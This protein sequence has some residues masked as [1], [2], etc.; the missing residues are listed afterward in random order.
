MLKMKAAIVTK[1]GSASHVEV[2]EVLKPVPG[3]K[4]VLIKIIA[5]SVQSGDWRVRALEMPLGMKFLARLIYGWKGPRQKILGT[6]FAGIIEEVGPQVSRWKKGDEVLGAAGMYFGAHAE[7]IVAPEK[8]VL[9]KKPSQISFEEAAVLSFGGLTALDYLKYKAKV[10]KQDKILIIG[11]SGAVGVSA[12][13]IARILG[14]HIT[15]VCSEE[16]S[17]IV[18]SLGAEAII[19]YQKENFWEKS[20]KFDIVLDCVGGFPISNLKKVT[21]A[22]GKIVLVSANLPEMISSLFSKTKIL[23]GVTDVSTAK[24][25]ELVDLQ[26]KGQFRSVI[27]Q[28]YSLSQI[29]E[30][31]RCVESRH[32]LGNIV[33]KIN[34]YTTDKT[35]R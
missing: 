32:K 28:I 25:E 9:V 8:S 7:F 34:E 12:V 27:S 30:A 24:L 13:Q 3:P 10:Q 35:N 19:N 18:R 31:H 33:L 16:K 4:D 26:I 17:D 6:E 23:V 2:A 22:G 1:Y 20:A 11:A 15:A 5:A 29:Q 21:A 14:A